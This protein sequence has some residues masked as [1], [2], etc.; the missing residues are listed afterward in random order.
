MGKKEVRNGV[1]YHPFYKKISGDE[2]GTHFGLEAATTPMGLVMY[3]IENETKTALGVIEPDVYAL[4]QD[5]HIKEL[6]SKGLPVK[7]EDLCWAYKRP[8][9]WKF[10]TEIP[11]SA[12]ESL[13]DKEGTI[14]N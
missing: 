8:T 7:K 11:K 1:V 10:T 3:S 6:E 14:N 13:A 12:A 2:E 4:E 5:E 9:G